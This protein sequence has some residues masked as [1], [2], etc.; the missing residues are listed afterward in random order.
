VA[1]FPDAQQVTIQKAS[2]ASDEFAAALR[3]FC[4][5]VLSPGS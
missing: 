3:E 5:D 1:A 2:P 4:E